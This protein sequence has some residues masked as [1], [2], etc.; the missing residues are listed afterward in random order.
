LN[1][2]GTSPPRAAAGKSHKQGVTGTFSSSLLFPAR[3]GFHRDLQQKKTHKQ[4]WVLI[5]SFL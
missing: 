2:G 1:S 3:G 5:V 4:Q